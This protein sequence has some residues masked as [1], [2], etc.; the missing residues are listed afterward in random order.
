MG[1]CPWTCQGPPCSGDEP[2]S[3]EQLPWAGSPQ[4]LSWECHCLD[5]CALKQVEQSKTDGVGNYHGGE[6]R[7]LFSGQEIPFGLCLC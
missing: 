4:P 6:G 1:L 3:L 5:P 7:S 2:F